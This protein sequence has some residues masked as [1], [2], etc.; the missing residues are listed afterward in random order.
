MS[1]VRL[2]VMDAQAVINGRIHGSVADAVIASLS[3]EPETIA[4]LETALSRFSKFD[5]SPF[6]LFRSGEDARPWDAGIVIVDMAGRIIAAESTYSDPTAEGEIRY[7]NGKEGTDVW[8]PYRIPEDWLVVH[9][10]LEYE[11]MRDSRRDERL[12]RPHVDI[13]EVLYGMPLF[14]FI[15]IEC[16][17]E[18]ELECRVPKNTSQIEGS[19]KL[20]IEKRSE[21]EGD[22]TLIQKVHGRWLLTP[23]PE[24]GGRS[25]RD[26]IL[27]KLNFIDFDLQSREFQWSVLNEGPPPLPRDSQ[28]YLN[29]GFGTHEYVIYYDFVRYLLGKCWNRISGHRSRKIEALEKTLG[30]I[31]RPEILSSED[32]QVDVMVKWLNE[33]GGAWLNSP[34][35]ELSG[36]IPVAIVESERRRIPL[37][38]S[39]KNAL[40]DDCPL[41]Q[42]IADDTGELFGPGFLHYDGSHIDPLFEFSTCLTHEEWEKEEREWQEYSKDFERRWARD[43]PTTDADRG[44]PDYDDIP[45]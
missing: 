5:Q 29:G 31:D 17:A 22:D 45:Y 21:P 38:S 42:M 7:H 39:A 40:F 25:P 24:L 8:L 15:V 10:V 28:A 26:V 37:L 13:R 18:K 32:D 4:E 14:E 1:E 41:C 36:S 11:S 33:S 3:A 43:H 20:D 44:K 35:D 2:N 16:L 9:S 30:R 12:T 34:C 23:R 19:S 6:A 27:E